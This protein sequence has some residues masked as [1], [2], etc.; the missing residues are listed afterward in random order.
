MQKQFDV[1]IV[2]AGPA[3]LFFA[4]ELSKEFSVLVL[5][6][7]T[8]GKSQKIW[9]SWIEKNIEKNNLEKSI[10]YHCRYVKGGVPYLGL[11]WK[12]ELRGQKHVYMIDEDRTLI[13]WSNE[14]KNNGGLIIEKCQFL[15]FDYID[16]GQSVEAKTSAGLFGAKLIIDA[17][18]YDS[19]IVKKFKLLK[20][21]TC[22]SQEQYSPAEGQKQ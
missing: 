7:E 20:E 22:S 5:E 1:I 2:G 4:K 3:G 14:T 10:E 12:K 21:K 19:P 16:N 18:G 15:D 11:E 6:K 8:I 17:S 13:K 9:A